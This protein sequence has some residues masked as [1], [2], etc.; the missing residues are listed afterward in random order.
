MNGPNGTGDAHTMFTVVWRRRF[1]QFNDD[2]E[3]TP[4][5]ADAP[6]ENPV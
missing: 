2:D 6:A 5:E 1:G 3:V 4:S